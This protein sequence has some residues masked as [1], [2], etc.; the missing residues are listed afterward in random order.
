MRRTFFAIL[1]VAF[2]CRN[3][4]PFVEILIKGGIIMRGK[5]AIINH[6]M[7]QIA[8]YTE[9]NLFCIAEVLEMN[10]PGIGDIIS[11]EL[12]SL[13]GE[14]FFNETTKENLD[15]FV[16]DLN[17]NQRQVMEQLQIFKHNKHQWEIL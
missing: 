5:V 4:S 1:A 8:I 6:Q 11:G 7:G 13:G 2:L 16:E 9:N 10:L 12:E 17:D 15:V 3:L 14:T